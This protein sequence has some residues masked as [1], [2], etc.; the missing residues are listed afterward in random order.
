MCYD[1]HEP[2]CGTISN[3]RGHKIRYNGISWYYV[4]TNELVS[5]NPNRDCGYCGLANTPEGHD[6]CLG[7]IPNA[8][9]ACCGHGNL[10]ESYIQYE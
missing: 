9:N 3:Y 6:G 4:D 5:N 2:H 7:T 1:H 10:E 8:I